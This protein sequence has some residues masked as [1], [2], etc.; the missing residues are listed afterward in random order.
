MYQIYFIKTLFVLRDFPFSFFS[1]LVINPW[2]THWNRSKNSM[3]TASPFQKQYGYCF[4]HWN[5]PKNS[6]VT[7]SH[8]ETVPKTVWLLL[9]TLKP[10]QKQYGYC[11]THW[12]RPKNSMVTASHSETVTKT[13]WL[14]IHT[15][16]PFQKQYG[17]CQW[18]V[19]NLLRE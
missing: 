13:V 18:K 19:R 11:F 15:L 8:T 3:V 1:S 6:M 9:H 2:F 4:T 17:Y 16:K 12:N 5:R 14:L 7:A 10:F